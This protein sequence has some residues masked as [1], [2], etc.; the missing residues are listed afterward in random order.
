MIGRAVGLSIAATLLAGQAA[1]QGRAS[2]VRCGP[3]A[4]SMCL[5]SQ[6]DI[7][8]ST[9]GGRRDA[10]EA[11][12]D[13]RA[14]PAPTVDAGDSIATPLTLLVLVD[15]SGSMRGTGLEFSRAALRLFLDAL[16]TTSVLVAVAPFESRA[17]QERIAGAQFQ[18]PAEAM[19]QLDRLPEPSPAGNT[20]LYS[21]LALGAD[22]VA[23]ELAADS[24][25]GR[26]GVVLLL[27]DGRNDVGQPGDDPNLLQGL[28]GR[29]EATERVASAGVDLWVVGLGRGVDASELQALAGSGRVPSIVETDPVAL[30]RSLSSIRDALV[31]LHRVVVPIPGALR[32]RL[33]RG[34]ASLTLRVRISSEGSGSRAVAHW[35]PPLFSLPGFDGTAVASFPPDFQPAAGFGTAGRLVML[36]GAGAAWL[37]LWFVA[38]LGLWRAPRTSPEPEAAPVATAVDEPPVEAVEVAAEAYDGVGLRRDVREAPPRGMADDTAELAVPDFE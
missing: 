13:G 37:L 20:A 26:R 6:I 11:S 9:R 36:G 14:L 23:R 12:L 3:D 28:E 7:S 27:T 4:G 25:G 32:D 1:G 21:A 18:P 17:V 8:A 31:S 2:L 5:A 29:R 30:G 19:R 33:A 24:D 15:V 34:P 35:R 16:P 22:R 10:W 38:P